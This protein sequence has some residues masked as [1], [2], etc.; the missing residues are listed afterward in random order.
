M[1]ATR[2]MRGTECEWSTEWEC[3]SNGD[4]LEDV[5][6]KREKTIVRKYVGGVPAPRVHR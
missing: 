5:D 1:T 2:T 3:E 4:G 6:A